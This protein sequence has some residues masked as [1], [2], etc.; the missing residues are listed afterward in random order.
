MGANVGMGVN[1]D[2]VVVYA[3]CIVVVAY[4]AILLF[5]IFLHQA[6]HDDSEVITTSLEP[7]LKRLRRRCSWLALR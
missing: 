6:S 2:V 4:V 5:C 7:H 3:A 1:V